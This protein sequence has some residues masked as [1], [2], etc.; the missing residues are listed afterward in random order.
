MRAHSQDL[1]Q[2]ALRAV[3]EGKSRAEI[4]ERF[5]VSRATI[6]RYVKQRR[7]TGNVRPRPIPG[8]PNVKGRALQA[9]LGRQL[10]AHPRCY[11]GRPL[12]DLGNRTRHAG[13]LGHHE[14]GHLCCRL[15]TKQSAWQPSERA[16]EKEPLTTLKLFKQAL[17]ERRWGCSDH[18]LQ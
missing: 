6:K 8:R 7:E 15:D 13:E 3:D 4:I 16:I 17:Q 9:Q 12:S 1:R 14:P 10:E 5:Q 11:L 18:A 2:R